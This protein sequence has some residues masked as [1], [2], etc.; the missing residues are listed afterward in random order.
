MVKKLIDLQLQLI[1][2]GQ[3]AG[4]LECIVEDVSIKAV[5]RVGLFCI[6]AWFFH[7]VKY[8]QFWSCQTPTSINF[9]SKHSKLR[10]YFSTHRVR[11]GLWWLSQRLFF[12]PKACEP[13]LLFTVR[14][15]NPHGILIALNA[16][17]YTLEY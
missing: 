17:N 4:V 6:C 8:V 7:D 5:W 14:N 3:E 16:H 13:N 10:M 12:P 11:Y 9:E 15:Q 1:E 2:N